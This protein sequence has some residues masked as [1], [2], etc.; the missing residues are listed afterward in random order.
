M[1]DP[2]GGVPGTGRQ[3]WSRRRERV[4]IGVESLSG[5]DGGRAVC[6]GRSLQPRARRRTPRGRKP[7]V[8]NLGERAH[9]DLF[10]APRDARHALAQRRRRTGD[11]LVNSATG[12]SAWNGSPPASISYSM[13]PS[14]KI[15]LR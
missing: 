7:V 8:G 6:A 15:S 10:Q 3:R 5:Q 4:G 13:T 2:G 14:A 9:H 11:V 1:T 12:V